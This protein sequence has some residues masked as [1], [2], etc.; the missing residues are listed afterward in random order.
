MKNSIIDAGP[1]IALF[2]KDDKFHEEI[3]CFL[4]DYE[5]YLYTTWPVVTEVMHMLG[6]NPN[7]QMNFLKFIERGGL[8][9]INLS[10]NAVARI[11][12]LFRQYQDVPVDLADATLIVI[13]EKE[14][15]NNIITIDSDFHIYRNENNKYIKNIFKKRWE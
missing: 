4:K 14:N 8:E 11:V 5:G 15:I 1:L 13:L 2:N 10:Q 12:K 6:A 3:K 9:V 7:C